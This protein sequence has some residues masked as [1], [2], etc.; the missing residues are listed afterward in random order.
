[1]RSQQSFEFCNFVGALFGQVFLLS[2]VRSEMKQKF[3]L[4]RARRWL[5]RLVGANQ[6]PPLMQNRLVVTRTPEQG[7]VG[8]LAALAQI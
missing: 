5:L 4:R 8:G 6:L 1:M 3:L 7:A 2:R